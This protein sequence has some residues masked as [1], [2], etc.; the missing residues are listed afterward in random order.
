MLPVP[1]YRLVAR[2]PCRALI[3]DASKHAAEVSV[4]KQADIDGTMYLKKSYQ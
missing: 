2:P 1:M 4:L 3:S